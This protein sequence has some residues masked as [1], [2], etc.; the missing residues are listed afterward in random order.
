MGDQIA[1]PASNLE[2]PNKLRKPKVPIAAPVGG[3]D[4]GIAQNISDQQSDKPFDA[5][6]AMGG[7]NTPPPLTSPIGVNAPLRPSGTSQQTD[8]AAWSKDAIAAQKPLIDA[9]VA[10]SGADLALKQQELEKRNYDM[11]MRMSHGGGGRRGHAVSAPV[12]DA[13]ALSDRRIGTDGKAIVST[14][15]LDT[16]NPG[17]LE[18]TVGK[19]GNDTGTGIGRTLDG[20]YNQER[21]NFFDQRKSNNYTPDGAADEIAQLPGV[22][23]VTGVQIKQPFIRSDGTTGTHTAVGNR[24]LSSVPIRPPIRPRKVAQSAIVNPR[25]NPLFKPTALV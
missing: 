1:Q 6:I 7:I 5:P 2:D 19:G 14:P 9:Q 18:S 12:P 15:S 24:N 4:Q 25:V 10:S 22:S 23:A 20:G 8:P 21:Q 11:K 17:G 13:G 3:L 16:L